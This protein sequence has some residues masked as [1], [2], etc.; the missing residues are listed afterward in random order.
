[1]LISVAYVNLA[2]GRQQEGI[3]FLEKARNT[4]PEVLPARI[5]LAALYEQDGAHAKARAEVAEILRI[6]P[7]LTVEI[8]L[9][10]LPVVSV[11]GAEE[12]AQYPG[13][14]RAA[15]LPSS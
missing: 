9:E 10:L 4:A 6:R 3:E 8:A 1:M 2:S 13:L 7:D 14:L 12:L 5:G 15:G 11:L